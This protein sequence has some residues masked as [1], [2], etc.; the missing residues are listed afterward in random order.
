[1]V[2]KTE[3]KPIKE[4]PKS[5]ELGSVKYKTIFKNIVTLDDEQCGGASDPF[6]CTVEIAK[7]VNGYKCSDD[8]QRQSFYHE[9]VHHIFEILGYFE[10]SDDEKMVQQFSVMLDQFEK[11]KKF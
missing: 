3:T 7:T 2:K 6:G 4:I 8:Y 11:T 5:F 9:L 1:M 10:L